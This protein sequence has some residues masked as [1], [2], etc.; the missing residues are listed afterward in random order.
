MG[1]TGR[2]LQGPVCIRWGGDFCALSFFV[3]TGF[4]VTLCRRKGHRSEPEQREQNSDQQDGELTGCSVLDRWLVL[5]RGEA[6]FVQPALEWER[7]QYEDKR[8]AI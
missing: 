2:S 8:V 6:Q 4:T 7:T 3:V 1:P 5:D